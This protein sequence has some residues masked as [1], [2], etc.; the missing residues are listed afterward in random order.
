[1]KNQP[2]PFD[3]VLAATYVGKYILV[4]LTYL[5]HDGSLLRRQQLHGRITSAAPDGI[6]IELAGQHAGN[7][8]NMPPFLH[9]IRKADPGVYELEETGERVEDPDLLA[10]WSITRPPPP[11]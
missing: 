10:T 3:H 7:S 6:L 9:V 4:G 8:W 11:D 2:P 5:D 1:M